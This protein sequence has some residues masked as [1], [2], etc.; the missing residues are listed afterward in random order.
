MY[1]TV[2]KKHKF[3]IFKLKKQPIKKYFLSLNLNIIQK[4]NE[5]ILN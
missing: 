2:K 3:I 1:L 5:F 4:D